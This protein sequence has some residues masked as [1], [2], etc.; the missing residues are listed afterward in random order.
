MEAV[1]FLEQY[2]VPFGTLYQ[3]KLQLS[4]SCQKEITEI[5]LI[6]SYKNAY[7]W[8]RVLSHHLSICTINHTVRK[9]SDKLMA[10][11]MFISG[12]IKSVLQSLRGKRCE[13]K[14]RS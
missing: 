10:I 9:V 4:V 14:T 8:K 6:L 3:I 13:I 7:D 2:D 1:P 12:N 11:N 5:A